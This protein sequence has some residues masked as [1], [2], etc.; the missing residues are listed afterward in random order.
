MTVVENTNPINSSI[1]NGATTV[2]A[3]S[4]TIFDESD[5]TVAIEGDIQTTGF[6]VTGVGVSGGGTVVFSVAPANGKLVVLY[7]DPALKRETDYQQFGDWLAD[8]VNRDF[9]R[10]WLAIQGANKRIDASLHVSLSDNADGLD[11]LLPAPEAGTVL[12]WDS[13][14][15]SIVNIQLDTGTNLANLSATSGAALVGWAQTETGNVARSV[16]VKLRDI[17][18]RSDY[19]SLA[20]WWAATPGKLRYNDLTGQFFGTTDS[21]PL[22][23]SPGRAGFVWQHRDTAS[24]GTNELIP[25]AVFQFTMSGSGT[26]NA[27]ARLSQSISQGLYVF[28]RKTNDG[29]GHCFTAVGELGAYGSGL[30]N[31]L[32]LFQGSAANT[33]SINGTM[34]GVEV[35][36]SDSPNGGTNDYATQ[37]T[38]VVSRL[39]VYNNNIYGQYNFMPSSEGDKAVQAM[40]KPNINGFAQW[41]RAFDLTG[42]TYTTGETMLSPNNTFVSWLLSTGASKAILGIS[43]ADNTILSAPKAGAAV[44]LTTNTLSTAL[45]ADDDASGNRVAIHV[46]GAIQRVGVGAANSG[47]AGFRA[48]IVP[49]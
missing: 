3:Y 49:N 9:D 7:L 12:G 24:V 19:S 30:Y 22:D 18:A 33:G 14:K 11:T 26:V 42:V 31:E 41:Q 1:A 34:S 45:L 37:M 15:L 8:E 36:L 27:G 40:L 6:S 43:G 20:N 48:L 47:G 38:G 16:A 29:S 44:L 46:G 10:I 25:G 35:L 17:K 28:S 4:F 39:A 23:Y 21:A 5:I 32:G 13:G 2:F